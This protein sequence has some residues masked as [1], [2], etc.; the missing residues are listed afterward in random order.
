MRFGP[1]LFVLLWPPVGLAADAP[2]SLI[3]VRD[4]SARR[5][6][7]QAPARRIVTLSPHATELVYASGAGHKLV[8]V[9]AYSDYPA[10]AAQ[11][12]VIGTSQGLDREQLLAL[13]PDL[14]VAWTSGNRPADLAWLDSLDIAVYH[15]EPRRLADI[16]TNLQALGKLAGT[17][18]TAQP[19]AA[20]YRSAL[21]DAC[22][23]AGDGPG[24]P[25]FIALADR[26]PMTVGGGHW[27]DE[28]ARRAGLRNIYADLPPGT[29]VVSR[30]S[31]LARRPQRVLSLAY[32]GARQPTTT[33]V[34]VDPDL[35]ARPGP[36]L[37]SAIAALCERLRGDATVTQ[38][39]SDSGR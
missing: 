9:A 35:W 4:D 39:T 22:P 38:V 2:A 21:A 37:P 19:A 7:L 30:E 12:P 15:S 3:E 29:H 28:A 11:L 33:A 1:L 23:S 27:L 32:P 18:Q 6:T 8:A 16:A 36:R 20:R 25:T 34:G 31:L 13:A 5:V 24:I 14:V 10:G 26:P 17:S